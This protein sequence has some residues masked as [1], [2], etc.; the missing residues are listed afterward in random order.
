[1]PDAVS[2]PVSSSSFIRSRFVPGSPRDPRRTD[3]AYDKTDALLLGAGAVLVLIGLALAADSWRSSN[4]APAPSAPAASADSARGRFLRRERDS[5]PV[6]STDS[7]TSIPTVLPAESASAVLGTSAVSGT[8]TATTTAPAGSTGALATAATTGATIGATGARNPAQSPA[9]TT[10]IA[11]PIQPPGSRALQTSVGTA[12][13]A[14]AATANPPGSA[15]TTASAPTATQVPPTPAP[16]ATTTAQTM[17]GTTAAAPLPGATTAPSV[18]INPSTAAADGWSLQ[19]GAFGSRANAEKMVAAAAL[20][21]VQSRVVES[22]ALLKVRTTG[23]P[24]RSEA[25]A[26]AAKLRA[27][28]LTPVLLKPGS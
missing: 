2:V 24:S 19:L 1:M 18:P 21:G 14:P 17:R 25:E 10:P 3:H 7:G 12:A 5:A 26:A 20:Q 6:P 4:G 16:T 27:N 22:G 8:A 28:G 23:F 13:T 9:V 15:P 11:A